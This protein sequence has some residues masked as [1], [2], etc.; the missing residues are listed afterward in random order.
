MA[1]LPSDSNPAFVSAVG[2]EGKESLT[3]AGPPPPPPPIPW[4]AA[5]IRLNLSILV[6]CDGLRSRGVCA[7]LA[8]PH[9]LRSCVAACE[10]DMWP[11]I[12]L[13]GVV[14]MGER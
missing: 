9:V 1:A 10:R 4:A 7:S 14:S 8:S 3:C 12:A 11:D 6:R 13:R 2:C 5:N